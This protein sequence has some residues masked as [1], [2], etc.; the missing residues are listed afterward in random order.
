MLR[1]RPCSAPGCTRTA[2]TELGSCALHCADLPGYTHHIRSLIAGGTPLLG[3]DISGIDLSGLEA[4]G[5]RMVGCNVSGVLLENARMPGAD[6]QLVFMDRAELRGAD[7]SGCSI[8]NSVFAAA[9]IEESTF[10][11]SDILLCNFM[12]AKLRGTRFDHSNLYGSRFIGAAFDAVGMKDCNMT[13]AYFT[14][15][16]A[17]VDF[18]ASNTNEAVFVEVPR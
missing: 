13:R 2:L 10:M 14:R 17:G 11:E 4:P 3:Y 6:F 7:F 15:G 5:A 1:Q 12:G 16:A 18:R 8:Q 9:L